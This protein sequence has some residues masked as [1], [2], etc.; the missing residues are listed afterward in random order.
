M[1]D[2][3][4]IPVIGAYVYTKLDAYYNGKVQVKWLFDKRSKEYL[5]TMENQTKGNTLL[6]TKSKKAAEKEFWSVV[7]S[8]IAYDQLR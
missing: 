2:K 5:I 4:N 8:M 6:T 7:Y 1:K 3:I